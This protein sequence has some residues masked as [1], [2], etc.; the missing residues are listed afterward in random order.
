MTHHC[1]RA[2]TEGQTTVHPL[3]HTYSQFSITGFPNMHVLRLR[4]E[5][6]V[7]EEKPHRHMKY[8]KT[9]QEKQKPGCK[10]KRMIS[11]L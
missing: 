9:P 3:I 6:R 10:R 7:S 4:E 5:A 2:N 11:L 8:R 1:H